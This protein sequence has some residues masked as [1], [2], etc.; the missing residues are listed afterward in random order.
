MNYWPRKAA[1]RIWQLPV[2]DRLE[3]IER[4][5]EQW[6]DY[7]KHYLIMWHERQ[8]H[9]RRRILSTVLGKD[10]KPLPRSTGWKG[11]RRPERTRGLDL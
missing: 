8:A 4:E 9:A 1:Y 10:G 11:Y 7:I 2:K 3:A 5:P 6:R